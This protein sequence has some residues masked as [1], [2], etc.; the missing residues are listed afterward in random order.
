MPNANVNVITQLRNK[1]IGYWLDGNFTVV[2][3]K[4]FYKFSKK[5]LIR[6]YIDTFSVTSGMRCN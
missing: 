2:N 1:L 6:F 3:I 5:I 4:S